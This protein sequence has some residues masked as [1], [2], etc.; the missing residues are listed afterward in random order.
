MLLVA[1]VICYFLCTLAIIPPNPTLA[2]LGDWNSVLNTTFPALSD[3]INQATTNTQQ[4]LTNIL[5]WKDEISNMNITARLEAFRELAEDTLIVSPAQQLD[6]A[7]S[8]VNQTLSIKSAVIIHY[9]SSLDLPMVKRILRAQRQALEANLHYELIYLVDNRNINQTTKNNLAMLDELFPSYTSLSYD[10]FHHLAT[11]LAPDK[12]VNEEV[13]AKWSNQSDYILF[14]WL[15]KHNYVQLHPSYVLSLPAR[16][17]YLL[18]ASVRYSGHLPVALEEQS[19]DDRLDL[20]LLA[21]H[22]VDLGSVERSWL[23]RW[24]HP[25]PEGGGSCSARVDLASVLLARYTPCCIEY[26][27]QYLDNTTYDVQDSILGN[28][29]QRQGGARGG[30]GAMRWC[31][32]KCQDVT[33]SARRRGWVVPDL[34]EEAGGQGDRLCL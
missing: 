19:N 11:L 33:S 6:K 12:V 15:I 34:Q 10:D 21:T 5:K 14:T 20:L 27:S 25:L 2:S 4:M 30:G 9:T 17:V 18:H 3:W 32:F 26:M 22:P 31:Q 8:L 23:Q 29:L 7:W 13:L 24:L 16:R 1:I 28:V